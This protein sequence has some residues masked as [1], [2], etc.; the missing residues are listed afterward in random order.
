MTTTYVLPPEV[1][2]KAR[3]EGLNAPLPTPDQIR[4]LAQLL[5][6]GAVKR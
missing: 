3:Q 5:T 2:E 1:R 6:A 4:R